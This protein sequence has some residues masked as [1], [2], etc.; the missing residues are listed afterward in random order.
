MCADAAL[1]LKDENCMMDWC[2][3]SSPVWEL[4]RFSLNFRGEAWWS[5]EKRRN[6]LCLNKYSH[7]LNF[8]EGFCTDHEFSSFLQHGYKSVSSVMLKRK[9][10]SQINVICSPDVLKVIYQ[11]PAVSLT[12]ISSLLS[13]DESDSVFGS[14]LIP[15]GRRQTSD[16]QLQHTKW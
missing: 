14:T 10:K 16:R 2:E 15:D 11:D 9:R 1:A 4:W 8:N 3:W 7:S 5:L 13:S 6:I 12:F